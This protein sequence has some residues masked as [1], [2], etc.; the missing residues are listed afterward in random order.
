MISYIIRRL[1]LLIPTFFGTTLLVFWILNIA[2]GGPYDRKIEEIKTANML[3]QDGGTG[4]ANNSPSGE[5][6]KDTS[7]RIKRKMPLWDPDKSMFIRY[8]RWLGFAPYEV[9]WIDDHKPNTPYRYTVKTTNQVN[10]EGVSISLQKYIFPIIT[11]GE[12]VVYESNEGTDFD[13]RDYQNIDDTNFDVIGY[14]QKLRIWEPYVYTIEEISK[15]EEGPILLQKYIFMDE[16]MEVYESIECTNIQY[17]NYPIIPFEDE[18]SNQSEN[19]WLESDW[20]ANKIDDVHAN[21]SLENKSDLLKHNSFN[22]NWIQSDWEANKISSLKWF[23]SM[24]FPQN[25]IIKE[26]KLELSLLQYKGIFNGYLGETNNNKSVSQEIWTRIHISSFF[27]ITGFLLSYLVCIPLGIMKALRHGSKF[28]VA[29]S[30]IVFI[31]YSIPAYAFGVLLIWFFASSSS[32][33]ISWGWINE[34]LLP[35]KGWRPADWDT[36][37]LW[38]Q[39]TGQLKHALMP[40]ICYMLAS[41]ATLTVLM[42]NSLMENMSQDYVRTAFAKGLREKTVIFRHAV[43]NSL[44][45]MATGIGGLIGVFLAGSYL[46]EKV[47]NIDGIGL[48]GFKSI[49]NRDYG[50][51]LG[52]L[53]IGTVIRLM[54]NLISDI[55][56]ALIDPRIR[57]K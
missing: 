1:L 29:S 28:D 2:P 39:I 55:C 9:K 13:T 22:Q 41:F 34:A 31:G 42:K 7:K 35:N 50:I 57:F 17:K 49:Q 8:F 45:P 56:Y 25:D 30:A 21:L 43:R 5:L 10:E 26:E 46:I 33:L 40:T 16:N 44:I 3:K 47:F 20:E 18:L 51:F 23:S 38:G 32:P 27:G 11:N 4:T 53:V 52:F 12:I 24:W 14:I 54:G 36:L 6:N 37:S 19:F 48:L 15:T